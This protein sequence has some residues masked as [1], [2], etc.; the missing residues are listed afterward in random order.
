MLFRASQL[1]LKPVGDA[2][3]DLALDP[4]NIFQV[5]IVRLCPKTRVGVRVDQLNID[6]NLI[7][8]FLNA[9]FKDVGNAELLRNLAQIARST[10]VLLRRCSRDHLKV[11]N[12][13]EAR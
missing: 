6:A 3:C 11:R 13:R 4:K 2:L 7:G 12:L 1:R 8:R 9:A 5:A 10:F